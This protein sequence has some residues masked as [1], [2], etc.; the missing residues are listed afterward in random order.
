MPWRHDIAGHGGSSTPSHPLCLNQTHVWAQ[1][2]SGPGWYS[3]CRIFANL[4]NIIPI[5][6]ICIDRKG[7]G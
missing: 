1:G 2:I 3:D 6:I 7:E 4:L 5:Y